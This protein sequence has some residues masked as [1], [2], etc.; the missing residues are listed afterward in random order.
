MTQPITESGELG[1]VKALYAGSFDPITV[2]H[3]FVIKAAAIGF[4]LHVGVG[5]NP[6]KA[7]KYM[8]DADERIGLI[9][10]SIEEAGIVGNITVGSLPNRFTAKHAQ[11]IGCS[12]L[13][14]GLRSVTDF[15]AETDW[16]IANAKLAPD[17]QTVYIPCPPENMQV[18]SSAVKGM[19]GVEGWE[20]AA[21]DY[22]TPNVLEAMQARY[23]QIT[24]KV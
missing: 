5:V 20:E 9:E 13:I 21:K 8:F 23:E 12:V 10:T 6:Q 2:G 16:T 3:L 11:E 14:R 1:R 15:N 17:V 7:S 24:A 19:M 22:V 18:S 4:D